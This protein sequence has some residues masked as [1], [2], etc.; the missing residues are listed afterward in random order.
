M[1]IQSIQQEP[2]ENTLDLLTKVVIDQVESQCILTRRIMDILGKPG[3]DN[4][5]EFFGS[6]D[7]WVVMWTYPQLSLA[8]TQSLLEQIIV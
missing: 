2:L 8:E 1:H 6:G 7:R 4:D 5:M 3:V